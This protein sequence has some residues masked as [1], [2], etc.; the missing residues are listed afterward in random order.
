MPLRSSNDF[1]LLL[2][3]FVLFYLQVLC[4]SL[5]KLFVVLVTSTTCCLSL[6]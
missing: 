2:N 4:N 6:V 5:G 1:K 3:Y